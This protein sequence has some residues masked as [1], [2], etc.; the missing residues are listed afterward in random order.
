M[1]YKVELSLAVIQRVR[2]CEEP[3]DERVFSDLEKF[4]Q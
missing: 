1:T 2:D 4:W 3:A